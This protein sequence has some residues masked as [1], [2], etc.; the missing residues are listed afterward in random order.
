MGSLGDQGASYNL[1]HLSFIVWTEQL[2]FSIWISFSFLGIWV[3]PVSN[4][5]RKT[6]VL[7]VYSAEQFEMLRLA[8]VVFACLTAGGHGLSCRLCE[9][10]ACPP[11]ACCTSGSYTLGVCGCCEVCAKAEGESCGGLWGFAGSC[12]A[13]LRCFRQ[14]GR[15]R[16]Q[17]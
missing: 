9:E 4:Q 1:Q 2:S 11:P 7:P 6:T 8:L 12:A 5:I 10:G 13:G 17:Y 14:C 3:K 16:Q 15:S